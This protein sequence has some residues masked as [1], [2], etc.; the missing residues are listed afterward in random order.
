MLSVAMATARCA[1]SIVSGVGADRVGDDPLAGL[2][3]IPG[4]NTLD[5]KLVDHLIVTATT[6]TSL[7]GLGLL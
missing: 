1:N 2:A 4:A 5:V 6:M 3:T 7:R